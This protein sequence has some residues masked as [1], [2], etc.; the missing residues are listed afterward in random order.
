MRE[1]GSGSINVTEQ[2]GREVRAPQQRFI[3]DSGKSMLRGETDAYQSWFCE[4]YE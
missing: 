2:G 4:P 3:W 1:L